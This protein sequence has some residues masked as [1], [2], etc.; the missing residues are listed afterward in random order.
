MKE[1]TVASALRTIRLIVQACN[2]K[3]IKLRDVQGQEYWF[4]TA[5]SAIDALKRPPFVPS[6][7]TTKRVWT[8]AEIEEFYKT[9]PLLK[10]DN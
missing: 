7:P 3:S 9:N 5:R 8:Q 6:A 2:P 4:N 1:N 10:H